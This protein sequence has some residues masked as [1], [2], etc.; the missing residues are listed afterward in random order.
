MNFLGHFHLS[1]SS[2]SLLVGNYIADMIKGKQYLNYPEPIARGILMHREIDT[3]TDKHP[4]FRQSKRR[5][6]SQYNHYS[7]V[8]VDMFY[9]HFLAKNWDQYSDIPLDVYAGKTY[10]ILEQHFNVIPENGK[11]LFRY[12]KTNNWLVRYAKTS[13]LQLAL[14]GIANRTRFPSGME[15]AVENL[16]KH[17]ERYES[18][19]GEFFN[20]AIDQFQP[21][22]EETR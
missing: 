3:F 17:Y 1:G 16:H 18:E 9:D 21:Y 2:E 12:M 15:T 11:Y 13:G 10:E 6:N 14:T 19:F 7:G 20:D 22:R 8:I 5:L 4:V